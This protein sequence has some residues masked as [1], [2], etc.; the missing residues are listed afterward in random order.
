MIIQGSNWPITFRFSSNMESVQ[1]ISVSLYTKEKEELKHWSMEDLT[2]SGAMVVAPITQEESMEF[3]SGDVSIEVKWLAEDDYIY[4]S[5]IKRT[6]CAY[7]YDK[8][9]LEA[10]V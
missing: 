5:T 10:E 7:R 1:D 9:V 3:P 6:I 8:T 4:H 2:I